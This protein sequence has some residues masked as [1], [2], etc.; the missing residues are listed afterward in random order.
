MA[1]EWT[2]GHC[3]GTN[4]AVCGTGGSSSFQRSQSPCA[5]V[6][7]QAKTSNQRLCHGHAHWTAQHRIYMIPAQFPT[8]L[9]LVN[10]DSQLAQQRPRC[11]QRRY[12][13]ARMQ[14]REGKPAKQKLCSHV[15][16]SRQSRDSTASPQ[17]RPGRWR[18]LATK[19]SSLQLR[20]R[21]RLEREN[22]TLAS[23]PYAAHSECTR[24]SGFCEKD[25][26][27]CSVL[28]AV[29]AASGNSVARYE[30]MRFS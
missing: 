1:L 7:K 27:V 14:R 15:Q 20:P 13:Q 19:R 6:P 4:V 10:S 5:L 17:E 3:C 11:S 28:R 9:T 8:A 16:T 26:K 23:V 12:G 22:E 29:A 24:P 21:K 25:T 30:A 2:F 18:S